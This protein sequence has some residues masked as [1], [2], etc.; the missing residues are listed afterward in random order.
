VKLKGGEHAIIKVRVARPACRDFYNASKRKDM[1]VVSGG[2]KSCRRRRKGLV[3]LGR[4]SIKK[5][6]VSKGRWQTCGGM[7]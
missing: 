7:F 3:N 4:D 1:L 2:L 6:D 5:G